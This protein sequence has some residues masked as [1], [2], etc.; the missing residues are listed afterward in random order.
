MQLSAALGWS[1][2][3]GVGRAQQTGAAWA[4]T[5]ELAEELDDTEYRRRALWGLCIDQFNNGNVGTAVGFARRFASLSANSTDAIELMMADRI[6]ATALHYL[7]DQRSARHHIDRALA[8][9]QS[10]QGTQ[11]RRFPARSAGIRTLFPGAHLVAARFSGSGTACG[12]AQ[13]RGRAEIGQVLSYCSVLGQGAC[14][15]AFLSGDLEAAARY[16]AML[17]DHTERHPYVS[18][19]FGRNVSSAW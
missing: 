6:Q 17:I 18:G 10:R 2:M 3:Y 7:G 14:P 15:V 8:H 16:C 1:L 5:L 9:M 19:T 12:R 13:Y 11:D 4:T